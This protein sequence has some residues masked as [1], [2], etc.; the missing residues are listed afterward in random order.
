MMSSWLV[1]PVKIGDLSESK[2][3]Q[4][5]SPARSAR[6]LT[7]PASMKEVDLAKGNVTMRIALLGTWKFGTCGLRKE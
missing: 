5:A 7:F 2:L 1:D 6:Q 3:L 4:A